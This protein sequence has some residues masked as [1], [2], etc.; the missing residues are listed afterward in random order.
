MEQYTTTKQTAYCPHC[1]AVTTLNI[2][3]T[4]T[5]V[6]GPDG[7]EEI[8]ASRTYHCEACL[9]FIRGNED[10]AFQTG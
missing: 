1:R 7:D 8:V 6:N 10:I 3:I 5:C 9:F 2:S 4:L